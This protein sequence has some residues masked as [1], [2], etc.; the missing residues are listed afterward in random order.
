MMIASQLASPWREAFFI[1]GL[2]Q[3]ADES[4]ALPR[5]WGLRLTGGRAA[6]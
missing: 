6:S 4:E 3:G 1:V 5:D 2:A